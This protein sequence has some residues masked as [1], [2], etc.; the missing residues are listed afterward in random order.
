MPF[1]SATVWGSTAVTQRPQLSVWETVD[2]NVK[3]PRSS[4]TAK[5]VL[6]SYFLKYCFCCVAVLIDKINVHVLVHRE[7]LK[8]VQ[9]LFLE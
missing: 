6:V 2:S 9:V 8:N 4:A 1:G 7:P 5:Y 3:K